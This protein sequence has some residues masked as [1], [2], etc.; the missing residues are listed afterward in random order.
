MAKQGL[1]PGA[2]AQPANPLQLITDALP[3]LRGGTARVASAI[4]ASPD[5]IAADS[6]TRLAAAADTAPAT[7]TRLATQL[8]FDGYPA[9]RA[10]I[11]RES[12][13]AAQS[14]WESDIG[15]A[16]APD[17]PSDK[18]LNVLASTEVNALRNAL[19]SIDLPA[20]E[21]AAA[22]IA[23]AARVHVY[24]E[25]GDAIAAQELTI[26]LLRIGVPVWFHDGNQSSRIGAGLLSAGDAAVVVGRAGNDPIAEQFLRRSTDQGATSVV[27]TGEVG[28][29][30]ATAGDIVLFTGTRNGRIWT[31]F[32]AGR[33]SDVLTTGLLFVLVAQR[34]P[35]RVS[36]VQH[37]E[38]DEP[39]PTHSIELT[40]DENR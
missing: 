13:R 8:G 20:V 2:R 14:A 21:R 25:W 18:V 26:R 37:T 30:V 31:E 3:R 17:D 19:A 1:K 34:L 12:G 32:F 29:A 40:G 36:A 9:L 5:E 28:S 15:S 33:A 35:E 38:N 39:F 27:I 16:I 7:V 10:A 6:I 11:A 22:A 24:G 4:L 23:G